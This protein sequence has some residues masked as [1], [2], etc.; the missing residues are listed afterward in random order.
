[1]D[2]ILK[3]AASIILELSA[4]MVAEPGSEPGIADQQMKLK[5]DEVMKTINAAVSKDVKVPGSEVGSESNDETAELIHLKVLDSKAGIQPEKFSGREEEFAEWDDLY[6]GF[7]ELLDPSWEHIL[8]A[9]KTEKDKI[10]T[11]EEFF[12]KHKISVNLKSSVIN[13]MNITLLKYTEGATKT[14]IQSRGKGEIL[15]SYRE[16]YQK[17]VDKSV[18][19][20]LDMQTKIT[21]PDTADGMEDLESKFEKW[22]KDLRVFIQI[23]GKDIPDEQ[24]ASIILQ[25]VPDDL[26]EQLI[27]Q[28]QSLESPEKLEAEIRRRI[29]LYAEHKSR[30]AKSKKALGALDKPMEDQHSGASVDG[31]TQAC[32]W[33]TPGQPVWDDWY[34][35]IMM[36]VPAAKRAR[37]DDDAASQDDS[38]QQPTS[39]GKGKGKSKGG[40]KGCWTCG[41]TEHLQRQC[42]NNYYMPK[43]TWNGWYPFKGQQGAKGKGKGYVKGKGKGKGKADTNMMTMPM[44][45]H[46]LGSVDYWGSEYE[47][48]IADHT[49]LLGHVGKGPGVAA[50]ADDV[51]AAGIE[52][53]GDT[54]ESASWD[55]VQAKRSKHKFVKTNILDCQ[56]H[57]A[58]SCRGG[59]RFSALESE[60]IDGSFSSRHDISSDVKAS[61]ENAQSDPESNL[62]QKPP[63]PCRQGARAP[64]KRQPPKKTHGNHQVQG[65][66]GF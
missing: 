33:D 61:I 21:N 62:L 39:K 28:N 9:I 41:S 24:K 45:Y 13:Q 36:A 51:S 27:Q 5:V 38:S 8:S 15:D 58:M 2:G 32:G 63:Q 31:K 29:T 17:H 4:R 40:A 23:G 43:T 55:L 54:S 57:N 65:N 56:L 6:C 37:V 35:Y 34:G 7:M 12:K 1:M 10:K 16:L 46:Q 18:R 26:R 42:P 14:R 53:P 50:D 3:E 47:N 59:N 19:N 66:V 60:N 44:P 64:A 49:R 20:K 11:P 22:E 48:Q 25:I 30:K 52:P